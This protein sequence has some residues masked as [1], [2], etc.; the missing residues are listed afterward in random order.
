MVWKMYLKASGL[1]GGEEI[2]LNGG[3]LIK[4]NDKGL[5]SYHRD[6]FDMG[7]FI[8]EHIPGLSWIISIVKNRLKAK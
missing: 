3:S 5:V 2:I 6:Y 4:F 1:K 7:E 8:Y